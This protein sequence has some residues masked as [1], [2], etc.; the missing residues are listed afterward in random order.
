MT[1]A[2]TWSTGYR[3]HY[4][5]CLEP[6]G[7]QCI[8]TQGN[9]NFNS[10]VF[11]K[12]IFCAVQKINSWVTKACT[13]IFIRAIY[14]KHFFFLVYF[15]NLWTIFCKVYTEG[16]NARDFLPLQELTEGSF[17]HWLHF[18]NLFR[19]NILKTQSFHPPLCIISNTFT[20]AQYFALPTP[21][22]TT[23]DNISM[24]FFIPPIKLHIAL[25]HTDLPSDFPRAQII[26]TEYC[27]QQW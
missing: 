24:W 17:E 22:N 19:N 13:N 11:W 10:L 27:W 6:W 4:G 20:F 2:S 18:Y 16:L 15:Y 5:F 12:V 7:E 25:Y 8:N 1:A 21:P 14:Q 3:V 23:F 26:I 9:N